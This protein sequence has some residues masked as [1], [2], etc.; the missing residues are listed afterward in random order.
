MQISSK[1]ILSGENPFCSLAFNGSTDFLFTSC[2]CSI[3]LLGLF[4]AKRV[5]KHCPSTMLFTL[6][7]KSVFAHSRLTGLRTFFS[8]AALAPKKAPPPSARSLYEQPEYPQFKQIKQPSA[9]SIVLPHSGQV[10][11]LTSP[12]GLYSSSTL[13]S[14]VSS[15]FSSFFLSSRFIG[16]N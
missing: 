11:V 15:T 10:T 1:S 16:W 12:V 9:I 2:A 3:A 5:P 13:V 8:Q 6:W 14:T 7:R 4:A